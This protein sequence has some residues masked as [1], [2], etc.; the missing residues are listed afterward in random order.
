MERIFTLSAGTPVAAADRCSDNCYQFSI[1]CRIACC[2]CCGTC[3]RCCRCCSLYRCRC[4]CRCLCSCFLAFTFAS[5]SLTFLK[6]LIIKLMKI[7]TRNTVPIPIRVFNA[8][9]SIF[10]TGSCSLQQRITRSVPEKYRRS[11]LRSPQR[12]GRKSSLFS[13]E[14]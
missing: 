13:K 14:A 8:A 4:C 6:L 5:I 3:R 1:V 12:S 10:L 7:S 2:W 11:C 9:F